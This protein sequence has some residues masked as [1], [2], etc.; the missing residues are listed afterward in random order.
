MKKIFAFIPL[1]LTISC[2]GLSDFIDDLGDGYF[3]YGEGSPANHIHY[4]DEKKNQGIE[5]IIIYPNVSHYNH[6]KDYILAIQNPS[7]KW[8]K[9][10]LEF[11]ED[12]SEQK[13]DSILKNDPYYQKIIFEEN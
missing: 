12:L 6:N 7:Y 2:A 4:K 1:F 10:N 3:Y 9:I 8:I 13:A 11:F 5:K